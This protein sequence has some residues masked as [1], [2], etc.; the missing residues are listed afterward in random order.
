MVSI[1]DSTLV[2]WETR[3]K[4]MHSVIGKRIMTLIAAYRESQAE[5]ETLKDRLV[6][7][8]EKWNDEVTRAERA[9]ADLAKLRAGT[10][11]LALRLDK[12]DSIDR[13]IAIDLRL[14]LDTTSTDQE[15]PR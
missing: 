7:L 10:V 3:A 9:E 14:L 11:V 1:P 6:T 12:G 5:N 13:A 15:A 4:R 8:G 2:E